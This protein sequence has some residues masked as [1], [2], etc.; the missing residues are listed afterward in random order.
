[1]TALTTLSPCP[2][3]ALVSR[4]AEFC[5]AS[6][7]AWI[8][9]PAN[10]WT[11]IG[12]VIAALAI[13]RAARRDHCDHL[14]GLALIA[15][16]TGLGSAFFH[17]SETLV[18]RLFDYAGMYMGA[19][20]MLVVNMRRWRLLSRRSMRLLFWT[21]LAAPLLLMTIDD[22]YALL[23]YVITGTFCCLFVE[24][25]LYLRQRRSDRP[26]RYGWLGAYWC[27]FLIAFTVWWLDKA[28]LLCNPNNRWI[29]GHGLWHLL[30][31]VALY[32]VYLF[33]RQFGVLRFDDRR[34]G[35]FRGS[36]ARSMPV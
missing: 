28:K 27:V 26:T 7:C 13:L 1:M 25:L 15:M 6:L 14:R 3:G 35:K 32:L 20:Y 19:S 31:A 30:D 10:T 29:S 18:G 11:N 33:Y 5:E 9:Q 8:R 22:R 16:T 12:F 4:P 17:A 24:T 23:L 2:W 34:D 36:L 21:T